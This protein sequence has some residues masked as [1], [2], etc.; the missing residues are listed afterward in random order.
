MDLLTNINWSDP[1][2]IVITV[3]VIAV[4]VA[5]GYLAWAHSEDKW[6]FNQ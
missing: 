2:T 6:P 4:I 5:V 3:I 1:A